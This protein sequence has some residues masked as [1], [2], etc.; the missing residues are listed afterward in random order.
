MP[1]SSVHYCPAD[2]SSLAFLDIKP[3]TPLLWET[4]EPYLGSPPSSTA[5]KFYLQYATAV[6]GLSFSSL[7]DQS[8][9]T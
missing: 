5:W 3:P 4:A 1:F 2:L 6:T 9:I 7:G 8:F